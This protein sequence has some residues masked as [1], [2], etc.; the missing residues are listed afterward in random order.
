M[1]GWMRELLLAA[2]ARSIV[3]GGRGRYM[4]THKLNTH[5][6]MLATNVE[7]D[8]RPRFGGVVVYDVP[9]GRSN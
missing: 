3:G 4:Y 9:L 6:K 1:D 8:D 5:T 7:L 2:F